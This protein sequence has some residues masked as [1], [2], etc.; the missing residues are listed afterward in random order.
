MEA[1][2]RSGI[3]EANGLSFAIDEAGEGDAVALCLHGFPESRRSWRHQLPVLAGMG[4]RAVAPDLRGYGESSRP[5]GKEAYRIDRLVE[6]IAALF[7]ALGAKRRLLIGHDWGGMV[8]WAAAIE[9]VREFHGLIAMNIPHPARMQEELRRSWRQRRRSWYIGFFQLPWLPERIL[10]AGHAR[11]I[12][13]AIRGTATNKRNFPKELIEHY[14]D[15]AVQPGAMTAMLNWYRANFG[16]GVRLPNGPVDIPTLLIWGD[17]DTALGPEL[18]PGTERYVSDLAV[19]WLPG[20][21]H[22]VQQDA[23]EEVNAILREWISGRTP[24]QAGVQSG[25]S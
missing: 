17:A 9:Q 8:A 16:S 5:L 15:N 25:R 10:T 19:K 13:R 14:R 24:A 23:P 2:I 18:V 3:V 11:A 21:S 22:W 7:D 12:G 6:D 4:W 20:I 1:V